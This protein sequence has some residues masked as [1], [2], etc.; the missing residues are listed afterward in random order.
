MAALYQA[1]RIQGGVRSLHR[2]RT[3]VS[4]GMSASLPRGRIHRKEY[5]PLKMPRAPLPPKLYGG[6]RVIN[7]AP[8]PYTARTE[9]S[10]VA[11]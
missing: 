6:M 2:N 5:T 11:Q 4:L 3:E 8:G 9:V 7:D 1:L 10:V